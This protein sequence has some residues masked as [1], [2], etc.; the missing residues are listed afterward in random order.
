MFNNLFD[1]FHA[2]VAEAKE[3]REQLNRLLMISTPRE[4]LLVAVIALLMFMLAAWL[5]FGNVSRNVVVDGIL[6]EPAEVVIAGDRSVQVF[7]W[8]ES[9]IAPTIGAGMPAVIELV[10]ADGKQDDFGG[11]IAAVSAVPL[12]EELTDLEFPVPVSVRRV[13]IVLDETLD[14]SSLTGR[15]CRVVVSLGKQ[16]PLELLK[17][18]RS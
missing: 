12:S 15:E 13:D 18:R 1:S 17:M 14:L 6:V 5:V 10:S 7:A 11:E 9:E 4:R 8:I 2:T 3:E 16:S